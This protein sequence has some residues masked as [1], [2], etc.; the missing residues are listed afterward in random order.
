MLSLCSSFVEVNK[1]NQ[2]SLWLVWVLRVACP[3]W[4][5][6]G[7]LSVL[8]FSESE[9]SLLSCSVLHRSICSN[10]WHPAYLAVDIALYSFGLSSPLLPLWLCLFSKS[11]WLHADK[12]YADEKQ[13]GLFNKIPLL[14]T[15]GG[16]VWD[17]GLWQR[18]YGQW[19]LPHVWPSEPHLAVVRLLDENF[20]HQNKAQYLRFK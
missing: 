7:S 13:N 12:F 5:F 20:M 2:K 10:T 14:P 15:W 8:P 19:Y 11:W 17:T 1:K 4:E 6:Q 16:S 18:P 9:L 3:V